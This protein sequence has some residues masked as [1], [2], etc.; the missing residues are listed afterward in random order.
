MAGLAL[1]ACGGGEEGTPEAGTEASPG[2]TGTS[3]L[4]S[5]PQ[6]TTSQVKSG[7]TLKFALQTDLTTFDPLTTSSFSTQYYIAYYGYPR[8]LKFVPGVY[9]NPP[10][11]EVEGDLAESYEISPDKL[12]LTF[13]LRQ[14]A[15]WDPRAPTN[16]RVIDAQD[17]KFTYERFAALSPLRGDLVWSNKN[18]SAPVESVT[19]PDDR[20]VVF[21]MKQPDASAVELFA[22]GSIFFVMP[23][24]AE[25]QFDPKGEV[26]G[27][28][29]WM[30][31][32]YERDTLFV[33]AKNPNWYMKDQIYPDRIEVP[34]VK[35]YAQ[36]LAQFRAGNTYTSGLGGAPNQTDMIQTQKDVPATQMYRGVTY[37]TDPHIT[38]FGYAEG[39]PFRD[40]RMRKAVSMITD[41]ELEADFRWN[42]D[43]F[44][45]L[46]LP[47][48]VR[49]HNA[50][51]A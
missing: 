38:I 32:R 31:E 47:M 29:P 34:I 36:R 26:R 17:V 3:G 30:L 5:T 45:G 44:T 18:P 12:Q 14:G 4:L 41:R 39:S 19:T 33:W 49:Y 42:R 15:A 25:S 10:S 8:M 7:G 20:T 35:E 9:P 50:V 51:P 13:K 21:K 22:A 11:G 6:E 48:P 46:G 27:Y 24:E 28:G 40:E 43:Q 16:S 23:R 2:P 37:S 1:L